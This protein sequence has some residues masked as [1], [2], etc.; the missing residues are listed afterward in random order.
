[1]D[2]Q[3]Q[4]LID[5]IKKDGVASAEN[6]SAAAQT[7]AVVPTI[8]YPAS[9]IPVYEF[10][11]STNTENA[12]LLTTGTFSAVYWGAAA[13]SKQSDGTYKVTAVYKSGAS[14]SLTA[15]ASAP[16]L[17]VHDSIVGYDALVALSVGDVLTANGINITYGTLAS[18]AHFAVP[19][20]FA[21]NSSVTPSTKL[22]STTYYSETANTTVATAK[23]QFQCEVSVLNASGTSLA[24]TA[25]VGTGCSIVQYNTDG[26]VSNKVVVILSGDISGD[27]VVNS[28]DIASHKSHVKSASKLSGCYL[29]AADLDGDGKVSTI[30]YIKLKLNVK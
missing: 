8:A 26:S 20:N 1:M 16:V 13:L 15:S 21:L 5:K 11:A 2:V 25:L 27:G 30:D 4:E 24:S 23:A 3:L 18:K 19:N 10:N 29:S 14:K 7:S 6:A 12:T 17:A 22:T 9:Y 28:T